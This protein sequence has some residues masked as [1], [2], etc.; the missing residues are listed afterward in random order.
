MPIDDSLAADIFAQLG[1][2]PDP[3]ASD[4][5]ET[6][7]PAD[8]ADSPADSGAPEAA[9]DEEE[10]ADEGAETDQ[11]S[12]ATDSEEIADET[13]AGA[14]DEA[15]TTEEAAPAAPEAKADDL[16]AGLKRELFNLREEIRQLRANATA[17]P[18]AQ[19]RANL[20]A[21]AEVLQ[22]QSPAE[23]AALRQKF[24]ELEDLATAHA[25]GYEVPAR[26]EGEEPTLYSRE[27]MAQIRV[28]ARKALRLIPQRAQ[29]LQVTLQH[30][31]AAHEFYTGFNDPESDESRAVQFIVQ[32]VPELR[33]LPSWKQI[34]GDAIVGEKLRL[35]KAKAAAAPNAK[36]GQTLPGKP[37]AQAVRRPPPS[38]PGAPHR[39]PSA[40]TPRAQQIKNARVRASKTGS[41][42]D[43]A[44][45]L[46][47]SL[48][49]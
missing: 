22:A 28:S 20:P 44:S 18:A 32:T 17:A 1:G 31:A 46:E 2:K 21:E 42:A 3:A 25:E 7:E 41:E 35:A 13:E 45:L 6:D 14:E 49:R 24:E 12:D 30:E 43:V 48:G 8:P 27:Q 38:V 11:A 40:P 16:P 33:R 29:A 5:E 36:N 23:L 39:A 26:K 47:L 15:E 34:I 10:T 9:A 19:A 4:T 37:A